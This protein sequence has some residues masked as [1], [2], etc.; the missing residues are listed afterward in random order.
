MSAYSYEFGVQRVYK[1]DANVFGEMLESMERNGAE[2]TPR[3]VLD[4]AKNPDSPIHDDFEWDDTV[5]AEKYRLEQ[6]R[7]MIVCLKRV[8]AEEVQ[9]DYKLRAVVSTP[10]GNNVYVPLQT[11]LGREDYKAHLLKQAKNDS[12][13]FLAKYRKLEELSAVVG[14]MTEF[15]SKVS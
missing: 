6:A 2:I 4:I 7:R 10:G 14:A 1:V 9:K 5:A 3:S 8:D 15:I 11:A 13:I 12:E